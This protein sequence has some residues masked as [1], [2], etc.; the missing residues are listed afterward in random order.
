MGTDEQQLR[1]KRNL[2]LF[3]VHVGFA[4]AVLAWFVYAV[5]HQ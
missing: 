5:T 1:R 4:L 2:L 3:A